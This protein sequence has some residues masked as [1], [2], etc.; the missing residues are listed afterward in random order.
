M[1]GQASPLY[2]IFQLSYDVGWIMVELFFMLSG[3]GMM[4]GYK[5]KIS[6]EKLSF[7]CISLC[8]VQ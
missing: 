4:I 8:S 1:T 5:K 2:S 3:L 6:E 7:C